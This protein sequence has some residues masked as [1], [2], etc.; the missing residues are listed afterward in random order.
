MDKSDIRIGTGYDV[1]RLVEGRKMVLGGVII[2]FE[3]G[4]LGHSDGDAL[5][6]AVADAILGALALGDIGKHFPDTDPDFKDIYSIKLLERVAN[7]ILDK[8]YRVSNLD[9]TLILQEPKVMGYVSEMRKNLSDALGVSVDNIS[10]KA[11]T[12]EGLGFTGDGAAVAAHA[13]CLLCRAV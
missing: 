4:T 6:H 1:H 13:V 7:L 5:S 8:G 3:K 9:S 10:V 11:T 12:E 2:P